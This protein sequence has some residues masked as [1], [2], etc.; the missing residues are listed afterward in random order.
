MKT[1]WEQILKERLDAFGHR[2]WL[3]VAD[4]AYPS[5]SKAGIETI[6]A[7]EEQIAVLEKVRTILNASQHVTPIVYTDEELTFVEE[8]YAP[9]VT[10]YREKL[11]SLL[12]GYQANVLP[13]DTII[14][15]L[16]QVAETFRVL[17]IKSNM[18]IPYT[19]VFFQLECGYWNAES[20]K[21]L[22]AAMKSRGRRG[23]GAGRKDAS[24]KS[25]KVRS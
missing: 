4:S 12:H 8:K 14:S 22:R 5:Q 2:N 19:S 21:R 15:K 10:A 13:H 18:R 24:S 9:G 16:D 17:L 11:A 23:G 20:E 7:D 25:S 6:V 3:V 1:N